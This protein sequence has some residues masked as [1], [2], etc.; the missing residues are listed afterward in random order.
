M[1]P[2]LW[3]G[4]TIRLFLMGLGGAAVLFFCFARSEL[5]ALLAALP[6]AA[7]AVP[8]MSGPKPLKSAIS[9]APVPMLCTGKQVK[10]ARS[11]QSGED[12]RAAE[13]ARTSTL[14]EK[15]ADGRELWN[16]LDGH[17][18]ILP[19]ELPS[20]ADVLAEED[21]HVYEEN[22]EG[23]HRGDVVLDGGAHYGVYVRHALSL[24]AKVVVAIEI[25]PGNVAC[26]RKTFAEEVRAGR[27]IVYPKGIWSRD[28]EVV[29]Q[30]GRTSAGNTVATERKD[31]GPKVSLTTIDKLVAEL[32]LPR[33]DFIKMDIEGAEPK[34][35]VGATET[36]RKFR[37]RLALSAYHFRNDP[38]DL[39]VGVRNIVPTYWVSFGPC[40]ELWTGIVPVVIFLH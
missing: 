27:V 32:R 3:I 11:Y 36:I 14:V 22:G 2:L 15:D 37:P 9:A 33:V 25:A 17:F 34:A 28:E 29:L 8:A 7:G 30:M 16:T 13:I 38:M 10:D 4:R 20:L 21:N 40:K 23:V 35:V 19:N 5:S 18:W 6:T 39:L 12:Q 26:L 24:G 31:Q 1:K